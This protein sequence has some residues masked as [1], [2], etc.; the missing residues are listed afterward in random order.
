MLVHA[1]GVNPESGLGRDLT[2]PVSIQSTDPSETMSLDRTALAKAVGELA[3]KG[4]YIGT[5]SWKYPGW[6]GMLYESARYDYRG[7]FAMTRFERNCLEEY[8]KVFKTVSVDAAFYKFPERKFLETIVS[9]VPDDFQF[10]F[11]VTDTITIKKFPNLPKFGMRAGEI[12]RDFLNADLFA[13]AFLKACEP[14]RNKI[15]LLMFEFGRFYK[16]DFTVA[17]FAAVIDLF[18]GKL[19]N[20]WP[21]GI[22]IRNRDFLV[23]EYFA[24]LAKHR[25]AHVY[26]SWTE[27]PSV[28]EQMAMPGSVTNP[29]LVAARFLMSPGR[30]YDDSLKL[31]QPYDRLREPDEDARKAGAA[32]ILGGE[33][34]E[35]RRKTFVY[36]NNRL[37]GNALETIAAM[38]SRAVSLLMQSRGT[39]QPQ[40]NAT[41][42]DERQ[43]N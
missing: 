29:N 6:C 26:N 33:R 28:N 13:E 14:F 21:Y 25:V 34:Y 16:T 30:K 38:I 1:I 19:P 35:P 2:N 15:G 18:F 12:N 8:G 31:F 37:E 17:Q 43:N 9:Q 22:E 4:V 39:T 11:K 20:D 41:N 42:A 23:P 5:S 10:S 24:V 3:Q 40:G 32:L 27:M 7:K 36:I